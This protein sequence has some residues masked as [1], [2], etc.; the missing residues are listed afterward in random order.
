MSRVIVG[1]V[2]PPCP[3]PIDVHAL[4]PETC[5]YVPIFGIRDFVCRVKKR[6]GP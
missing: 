1:R 5:E 2:I 4:I 6:E 3:K